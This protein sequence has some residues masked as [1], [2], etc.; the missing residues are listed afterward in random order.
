MWCAGQVLHRQEGRVQGLH[1]EVLWRASQEVS[2]GLWGSVREMYL[3]SGVDTGGGG[4]EVRPGGGHRVWPGAWPG[5]PSIRVVHPSKCLLVH[6]YQLIYHVVGWYEPI[7]KILEGTAETTSNRI[8]S[9]WIWSCQDNNK[10][11][12]Y[13]FR[14]K[15]RWL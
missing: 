7:T 3:E 5:S 8:S 14:R 10:G 4:G 6:A 12:C 2:P 13:G 15:T 1:Q 9:G 11:F